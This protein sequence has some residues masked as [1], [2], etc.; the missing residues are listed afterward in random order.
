MRNAPAG[1]AGMVSR[2]GERS[3]GP[4]RICLAGANSCA[5]E[6]ASL[7]NNPF[8]GKR[9]SSNPYDQ[10]KTEFSLFLFFSLT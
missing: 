3:R 6:S 10:R 4:E 7:M 5:D 9:D 2:R 8:H 1:G